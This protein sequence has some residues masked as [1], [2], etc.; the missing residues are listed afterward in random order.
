[1]A[2]SLEQIVRPSTAGSIRP[3]VPLGYQQP[4]IVKDSNTITWGGSGSNIFTLKAHVQQSINNP[5]PQDEIKRTFDVVK[6]FNPD[7]HDQHVT[8][9]AMTKYQAR[10]RVDKSRY[11]LNFAKMNPTEGDIEI[12]SSGNTRQT[13][14]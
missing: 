5:W 2:S 12:V 13:G 4:P 10:N 11:E 6:V 1:M 3:G 9:E 8:V 14:D 7:D